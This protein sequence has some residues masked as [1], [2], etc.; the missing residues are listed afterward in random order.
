MNS[1]GTGGKK[2]RSTQTAFDILERIA[3]GDR[4]SVSAIAED[5][6]Y[7]RSTVHYHLQT[8]QQ[9]R[10]VVHDDGFRLGLRFA[11]L[12]NLA[13][14]DHRLSGDV[15][16]TVD[17]LAAET[18]GVAHV[19]VMEGNRL[20]WF[21][22]SADDRADVPTA[23]GM[24]TFVHASAYGQAILAFSPDETVDAVLEAD[25][26]PEVT[27][28]TLTDR[29]ALEERLATAREL[30]F[31]YSA[32]EF[33]KGISSIAAPIV[34]ESVDEVVGAIGVTDDHERI[35]NPYKHTKA[36]RFSDELPGQV[37]QSARIVSEHVAENDA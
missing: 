22:R 17:N 6:E 9:S 12:G 35:D 28:H 5:V 18:G 13:I 20:V 24:D 3:E 16:K 4:P 7:S 10:Y 33:R 23:V 37:Q 29:E 11:R 15:E 31:A 1:N 8:L 36:R 25:G 19:A 34:D 30:G 26:L 32:Q 27:S 21:Y 2:I 14:E